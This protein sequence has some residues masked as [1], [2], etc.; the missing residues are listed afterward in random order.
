VGDP[1]DGIPFG[2]YRLI[3]RL[4]RGGMAEV[5]LA[6]QRGLEGFERR[7]AVKRILPHLVESSDFVEMFLDEARLAAR[8]SHPNVVH[9]YEF[10]KVEEYFFIAMEYVDGV[11]T[12]QL[13]LE[14]SG[15]G[16]PPE[17][18][19][20]IGADAAGGLHH[21]HQL[22]N[23]DGKPLGIVHRDVSPQNLLLSFDGVL[24]IVDFGIAK[25]A[26]HAER[27]RPGVVK[28][29]FAYMSPEQVVGKTLDGRSDVYSLAIVLWELLAGRFAF[30]RES[31]GEAMREIRDGKLQPIETVKHD[32]PKELAA[33]L[34]RALQKDREKRPTAAQFAVDLESYLKVSTQLA[35]SMV[36]SEWLKQ[37][38]PRREISGMVPKANAQTPPG[39]VA[40]TPEP[41][42][43]TRGG[44]EDPTPAD[45]PPV[46]SHAATMPSD[47][48]RDPTLSI[49]SSTSGVVVEEQHEGPEDPTLPADSG[50]RAK[51]PRSPTPM[52]DVPIS[53]SDLFPVSK[54]GSG[55]RQ[56]TGRPA[57]PMPAATT[58]QTR[59]SSRQMVRIGAAALGLIAGIVVIAVAMGGD[60][61]PR[62]TVE[63]GPPP[64]RILVES[65][66]PPAPGPTPVVERVEP[67]VAPAPSQPETPLA[68]LEVITT[69]PGAS[70]ALDGIPLLG[71]SPLHVDDIEPGDHAIVVSMPGH[72]EETRLLSL[73]TS[74]S[75]RLEITLT[76]KKTQPIS[77]KR[78]K[79]QQAQ[80]RARPSTGFLTVHTVPWSDVF[81]G[82]RKLGQ[83]PLAEREVPA[84]THTLVFKGPFGR[85]QKRVTIRPGDTTKLNLDFRNEGK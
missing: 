77:Q 76:P 15:R 35:T 41:E 18:V 51:L 54:S 33:A 11:D 78:P 24:K 19:A 1:R 63:K 85:R 74:A 44:D 6:T 27:T 22:S 47:Q 20:R 82:G 65:P 37:K 56:V 3:K 40:G 62:T 7:V 45:D 83:A 36:V 68:T 38:F 61:K 69:P 9:I 14:T 75:F 66:E 53:I 2:T 49:H 42:N 29:K 60:P 57:A 71:V 46:Y 67:E 25:A 70:V 39:T 84:G 10:G 55:M 23:D 12:N 30:S 73:G 34:G 17:I 5:F 79:P 4:A 13:I 59:L 32:V 48:I 81:L 31:P 64:P 8:L 72:K 43:E 80:A 58:S 21:A 28:G 26:H 16:I 50:M 52:P